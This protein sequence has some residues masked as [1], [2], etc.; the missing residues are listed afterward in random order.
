MGRTINY[1]EIPDNTPIIVGA[2]QHTERVAEDAQPPFSSP[3]QLAS[4]ATLAALNDAGIG[5]AATEID[6][7]AVIRNFSDSPGAWR[8]PFG[9]SNNPPESI[10]QRIGASPTHRIHSSAGGNQP[11]LLL[12]EIFSA[13]GRGEKQ[14][15]VLAGAEAIANQ[16]YA[17]RNGLEDNWEETFELPLDDRVDRYR[18]ATP[19]EMRSGMSVPIHYYALIENLQAH[20]L[21]HDP[22]QHRLYMARL[23]APFSEVAVNNP[24]SQSPRAYSA[25]EL[26]ET[27]PG[28]FLISLPYSKLLV[29]QDAVNQSAALVVTSVG[30]ARQLGIDPGQWIF[31]QGYAEGSDLCVINRENPAR[32]AVMEKVLCAALQQAG[33]SAADMDLVDIYSCFPCAVDAACRALDLPTDGSGELTLTG[34]LPFFG[35]PGNNYTTHALVEAAI[36]LRKGCS[37]GLVTANGGILSKH[38]AMVMSNQPPGPDAAPLN[39]GESEI[40][41]MNADEASAVA[42]ADTPQQG[43]ILTYTVM[44]ARKGLDTAVVMAETANGER[45][46]AHSQDPEITGPMSDTH[47]MGRHIKL[48]TLEERHQ[49]SF[50]D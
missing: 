45:F 37:R 15:A 33:A 2:A 31:V 39:W 17:E 6:T 28:N 47:P 42:V 41:P 13:I 20:Q 50:I 4:M 26:A 25:E 1:A 24:Y 8:C 10:A 35:G 40:S 23:M 46:M 48:T 49:F 21:V 38:A 5:T 12:A 22:Q 11:Q 7:I 30:K 44:K 27:G 9:T 29:A 32:S 36:R 43:S 34:G 3:V 14:M 16:R 19:E 18:F